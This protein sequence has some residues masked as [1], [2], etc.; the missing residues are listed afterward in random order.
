MKYGIE[1]LRY[2]PL[3]CSERDSDTWAGEVKRF[4]GKMQP[5]AR[6]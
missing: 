2:E 5:L 1:K 4:Q 3:T 6:A